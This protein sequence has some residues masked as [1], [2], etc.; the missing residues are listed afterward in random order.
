M[1]RRGGPY[2]RSVPKWI[3]RRQFSRHRRRVLS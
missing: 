3:R 1:D 2:V